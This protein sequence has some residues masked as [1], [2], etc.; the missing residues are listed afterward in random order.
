[1]SSQDWIADSGASYHMAFDR[2]A[3]WSMEERETNETIGLADNR[4]LSVKDIGQI[5]VEAWVNHQWKTVTMNNVR[6]IPELGKNL[7]TDELRAC[8]RIIAAGIRI[9]FSVRQA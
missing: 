7:V 9:R 5:K 3:F 1:M 8:R 2:K 4:R 6:W